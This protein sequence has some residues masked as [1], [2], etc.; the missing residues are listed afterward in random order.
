MENGGLENYNGSLENIQAAYHNISQY[1]I[2]D[3]SES[4]GADVSKLGTV[5]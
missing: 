2:F 4:S 1:R 3:D 5:D